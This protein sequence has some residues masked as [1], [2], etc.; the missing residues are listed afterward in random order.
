MIHKKEFG[1]TGH[2]STRTIFGAFA[3]STASEKEAEQALEIV[4]EHGINHIDTSANY[5][6]SEQRLGPWMKHYR[7]KFFLATKTDKRTKKE[8][9]EELHQSL[10]KLKTD[11][12]DLWQMHLLADPTE[13][14][15]A[16]NEGGALEAFVEARDEGLVSYL[17]VTGHGVS[18]PDMHLK[19]IE[20]FDFDSVLLPYNFTMMQ[21]EQYAAGFNQLLNECKKRNI[22]VQTIKAIAKGQN[23]GNTNPHNVWYSPL[24]DDEAIKHAVH[25]VLG[26][27][28]VF[29]NTSGDI[30]LMKKVLEAAEGFKTKTDEEVML[31]DAEKFGITQLF[32]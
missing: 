30:K 18:I 14:E 26:N 22:A 7:D 9:K 21:N 13:W 17:G 6:D 10:D 32:Q 23:T 28:D 4:L 3:L 1:R 29:L 15:T 2:L 11:H 8:A 27:E 19:S 24:T 5:G 12:L 25:W 16:M 31:S 20:K